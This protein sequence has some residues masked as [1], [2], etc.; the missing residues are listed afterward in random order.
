MVWT[1]FLTA[2]SYLL[3]RSGHNL[4]G[5]WFVVSVSPSGQCG[6]WVLAQANV[7]FSTLSAGPALYWCNAQYSVPTVSKPRVTESLSLESE[8]KC[9]RNA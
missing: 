4:S 1:Q 6:W 2:D 7:R 3:D 5:S 9:Q 8:L